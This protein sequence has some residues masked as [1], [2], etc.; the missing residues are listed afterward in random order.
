MK[1]KNNSTEMLQFDFRWKMFHFGELCLPL[2]C[3]VI[4]TTESTC[5]VYQKN[6]ILGIS[7]LG[8]DARFHLLCKFSETFHE[9]KSWFENDFCFF[10][11]PTM[12]HIWSNRTGPVN[13]VPTNRKWFEAMVLNYIDRMAVLWSVFTD[14]NEMSCG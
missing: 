2:N 5:W 4:N 11:V 3:V 7:T 13:L 1:K 6:H 10:F 8:D 12:S 14:V 9:N